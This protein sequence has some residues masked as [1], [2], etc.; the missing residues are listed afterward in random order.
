MKHVM[1]RAV[2][3]FSLP[4]S[5]QGTNQQVLLLLLGTPA[6]WR[7][8]HDAQHAHPADEGPSEGPC[9]EARNRGTFFQ[10]TFSSRS[11]ATDDQAGTADQRRRGSRATAAGPT[12]PPASSLRPRARLARA[13]ADDGPPGP[14]ADDDD[15]DTTEAAGCR[16]SSSSWMNPSSSSSSSSTSS[17]VVIQ[18]FSAVAASGVAS[19]PD[20]EGAAQK[21]HGSTWTSLRTTSSSPILSRKKHPS[22][23]ALL[24]QR[25]P[26]LEEPAT[27]PHEGAA[28]APS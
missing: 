12:P 6:N 27:P 23:D 26:G 19:S 28:S 22:T 18:V 25:W 16:I 3:C 9:A 17:N 4:P 15:D 20:N 24:L 1:M 7:P 8:S 21:L 13:G 14:C 10:A 2:H 11:V 5:T